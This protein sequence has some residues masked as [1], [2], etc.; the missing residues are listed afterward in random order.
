MPFVHYFTDS[1]Q[2]FSQ[3]NFF[4]SFISEA[5]ITPRQ[6]T[7]IGYDVDKTD[8]PLPNNPTFDSFLASHTPRPT[9]SYLI[10][11][12]VRL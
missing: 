3:G 7:A 10:T 12:V 6:N 4:K 9:N 11:R 2:F 1:R 5:D 8:S